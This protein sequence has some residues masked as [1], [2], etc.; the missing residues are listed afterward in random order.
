[1]VTGWLIVVSVALALSL[2]WIVP[3]RIHG[4]VFDWLLVRVLSRVV[5]R[6]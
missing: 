6:T 1:V 5:T 2:V 3:G 4:F